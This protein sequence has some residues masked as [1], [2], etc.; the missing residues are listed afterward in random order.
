MFVFLL[1]ETVCL[2]LIWSRRKCKLEQWVTIRSLLEEMRTTWGKIGNSRNFSKL[3]SK[4]KP[5][6][7][8]RD[9]KKIWSESMIQKNTSEQL[10]TTAGKPNQTEANPTKSRVKAGDEFWIF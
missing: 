2:G 6:D 1:D 7:N 10:R 4:Q 5:E 3:W 8:S 9:A